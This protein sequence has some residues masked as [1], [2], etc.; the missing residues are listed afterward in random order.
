VRGGNLRKKEVQLGDEVMVSGEPARVVAVEAD[1]D[2]DHCRI[3]RPDD[4]IPKIVPKE[5]IDEIKEWK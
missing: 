4:R 3:V 5:W 1:G 2:T